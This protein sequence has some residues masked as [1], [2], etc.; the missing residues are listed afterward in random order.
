[1][2]LALSTLL[3]AATALPALANPVTYHYEAAP[4][5]NWFDNSGHGFATF[6]D[7]THKAT[8]DFTV[9]APLAANLGSGPAPVNVTGLLSSWAYDGGSASTQ[10]GSATGASPY[11]S[12]Y[13]W[14]GAAGEILESL[15]YIANAPITVAGLPA[16][17]AATLYV[18]S[19][20]VAPN[21]GYSASPYLQER[22]DYPGYMRCQGWDLHGNPYC[23]AGSEG[24]Y[25]SQAGGSWSMQTLSDGTDPTNTVPEPASLALVLAGLLGLGVYSPARFLRGRPASRRS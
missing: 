22:V 1:M 7:P 9:A 5:A 11:F 19:G 6:A 23:Y 18:D 3:L 2:R 4:W 17:T 15:F 12:L 16:G 10:V 21:S 14:T 24:G 13:L 20:F 25:T 8:L